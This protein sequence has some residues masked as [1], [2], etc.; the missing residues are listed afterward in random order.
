M[1]I[2]IA[3]VQL[4]NIGGSPPSIA[5][6]DLSDVNIVS[7]Q[8]GQYLRYNSAISKWETQVLTLSATGDAT[9]TASNSGVLALTLA[10]ALS[11]GSPGSYGSV[12][13]VPVITVNA[14]GL[15]TSINSATISGGSG[16][17][18]SVVASSANNAISITGSPITSSGTLL[19]TAN[20]FTTSNPGVVPESGG[21]TVNF[22]R[23][24]GTWAAPLAESRTITYASS[25]ATMTLDCD[26]YDTFSVTLTTNT[27]FT[28]SGGYQGQKLLLNLR[29]DGTG[30][31]VVT[32]TGLSFGTDFTSGDLVISTAANS[33]SMAGFVNLP[34]FSKV[35]AV[36][37]SPG[38]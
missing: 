6:E 15:I 7:P 32:F 1:G 9:G 34:T 14:K 18:T 19:F 13:T 33:V 20:K 35:A 25:T 10:N 24:D 16:T 29:Q 11:S 4:G 2:R 3:G 22:L 17:V 21:G 36:M 5:L 30:S 37:S 31:R 28:F 26:L 8:N 27:Q 23:A 38:Y 12:T